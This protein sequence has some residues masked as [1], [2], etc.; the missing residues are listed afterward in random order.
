MLLSMFKFVKPKPKSS[1]LYKSGLLLKSKDFIFAP[2]LTFI[3]TSLSF[4]LLLKSM[5]I[6]WENVSNN[7]KN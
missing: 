1:S 3:S 2:S 4:G 7:L 5:S 6:T